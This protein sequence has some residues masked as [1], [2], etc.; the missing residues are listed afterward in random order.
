MDAHVTVVP[1][2]DARCQDLQRQLDTQSDRL[3]QMTLT[4]A[5]AEEELE[6]AQDQVA[7]LHEEKN[8]TDA[9]L[10]TVVEA[11]DLILEVIYCA[12]KCDAFGSQYPLFLKCPGVQVKGT[13]LERITGKQLLLPSQLP[14]SVAVPERCARTSTWASADAFRQGSD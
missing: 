10:R 4:K 13:N 6:L 8:A 9:R 11:Y 14:S 1:D 7:Q 5:A 2:L 3:T 12:Y